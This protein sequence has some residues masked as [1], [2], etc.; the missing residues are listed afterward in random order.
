[1]EKIDQFV[2]NHP[3]SIQVDRVWGDGG[4]YIYMGF[5]EHRRFGFLYIIKVDSETVI[6]DMHELAEEIENY[7]VDE[8]GMFD[9]HHDFE[10]ESNDSSGFEEWFLDQFPAVDIYGG[11]SNWNDI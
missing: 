8:F 9:R 3:N 7:L 4:K 5:N 6:H 11:S 2:K 1:M 10:E